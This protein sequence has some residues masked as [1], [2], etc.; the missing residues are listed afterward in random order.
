VA[1]MKGSAKMAITTHSRLSF[2]ALMLLPLLTAAAG[3]GGMFLYMSPPAEKPE[4]SEPWVLG[5][6]DPSIAAQVSSTYTLSLARLLEDRCGTTETSALEAASE[7][8]EQDNPVMAA[9]ARSAA[10]V[11]SRT[12]GTRQSCD[13]IFSEIMAAEERVDSRYP[14]IQL[15]SKRGK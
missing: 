13:Y 9:L 10:A 6:T 7:R 11:R 12:I 2:M 14:K 15:D 8:E 1:L 5:P 3:A 4:P